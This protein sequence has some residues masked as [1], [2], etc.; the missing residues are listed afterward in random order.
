M[1]SALTIAGSDPTGGAGLQAD[2]KVF[3]SFG[4]YGYSVVSALTAQSTAGV[5]SVVPVEEGMIRR[6][7]ESLFRDVRPDALKTGMLYTGFA[8]RLVA[9]AVK[10]RK[11]SNLVVDP[12]GVSST[13][14]GLAEDGAMGVI[15]EGLFPLA[16]VVTP[17]IREAEDLT[18][19]PVAGEGGMERAA[20]ALKDMGPDAVIVTGGHLEGTAVDVYY[21]G[22]VL[23]RLSGEKIQGEYHGTGCVFSAAVAA[24]LALGRTPLEAA[25]EAKEFVRWAI[26]GACRPGGGMGLLGI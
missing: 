20:R 14:V 22:V 21:D 24:L 10:E 18:G 6:Q 7:L 16:R 13:G 11:L 19:T 12:L 9:E 26:R 3:R 8:V 25:G 1:R 17:N 23:E 2:L 5:D 4:L 15:R